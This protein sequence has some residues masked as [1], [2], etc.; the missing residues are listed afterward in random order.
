M[1]EEYEIIKVPKDMIPD[2]AELME[3]YRTSHQIIVC[4]EPEENDETHNCDYMGC[5]T[6]N[7][8]LYRFNI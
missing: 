1:R 2:G 7:H 3:C 6:L 8:V 5:T 4:G